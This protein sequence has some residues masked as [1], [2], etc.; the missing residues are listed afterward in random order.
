M[1]PAGDCTLL[2]LYPRQYRWYTFVL[3]ID[4]LFP[5]YSLLSG[6]GGLVLKSCPTLASPWTVACQAPLSME[7][8]KLEYWSG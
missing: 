3:E 7:F 4:P 8:S 5:S 2:R 1:F 6:D